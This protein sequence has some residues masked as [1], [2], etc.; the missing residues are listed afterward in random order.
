MLVAQP[1]MMPPVLILAGGKGTRLKEL[2]KATPKYLMPI[3]GG[4]VFA[5]LH[6]SWLKACGFSRVFLSIGYLGE[7]I[8]QYCQDGN[9]W[10]LSIEYL[11]DG[12]V[13]LGTGGAVKKALQ[14]EFDDLCVTYGDTLLNFD[15]ASFLNEY[16]SSQ[17]QAA[18][19]IYKND[20]KGHQC[21]MDYQEPFVVY[22]KIH[23]RTEWA[24]IDYGFLVLRRSFLSTF[25]EP[26]PFDLATPLM[27][28]SRCKQVLGFRV[29]EQ[30]WEIGS[31]EA[32][33]AFQKRFS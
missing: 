12:D 3:G 29:G 30:F 4:R 6:L 33:A 19:T 18:M 17:A 8:R 16:F 14:F 25:Q 5:D 11:E 24:Y 32:L 7:Q 9:K 13:P 1:P 27:R 31:P 21:N 22:D 10:N 26:E 28:A 20:L 2:A 23:P 15:M